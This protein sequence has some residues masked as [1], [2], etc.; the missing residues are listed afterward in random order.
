MSEPV[1]L[2]ARLAASRGRNK[3]DAGKNGADEFLGQ[4]LVKSSQTLFRLMRTLA[5]YKAGMLTK[6][7]RS[8]SSCQHCFS[9]LNSKSR[10]RKQITQTVRTLVPVEKF[11][12]IFS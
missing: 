8:P 9:L 3:V 10:G 4:F 5:V 1:T 2:M 7:T 6:L 12:L 11:R